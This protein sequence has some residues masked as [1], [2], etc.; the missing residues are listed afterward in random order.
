[1]AISQGQI[2]I[3]QRTVIGS[4]L[5]NSLLV[6]WL[7][8]IVQLDLAELWLS[9]G[10]RMLLFCRGNSPETGPIRPNHNKHYVVVDYY[11]CY[12]THDLYYY[13]DIPAHR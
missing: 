7:S 1:M 9:L 2:L 6:L 5:L 12:F 11:C 10:S 3:V 8:W 13:V 4:I